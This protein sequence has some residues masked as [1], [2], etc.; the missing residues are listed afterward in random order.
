MEAESFAGCSSG[1][2]SARGRSTLTQGNMMDVSFHLAW[3]HIPTAITFLALGWAWFWPMDD[4][5]LFGGIVRMGSTLIAVVVIAVA[6]AIAG[7]L[8]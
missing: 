3:W 4:D 7:V 2:L 8:K 5:G 6:W 1:V